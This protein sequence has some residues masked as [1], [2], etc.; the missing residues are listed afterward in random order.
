MWKYN[1]L[2]DDKCELEESLRAEMLTCEEQ[3]AYIEVLKQAMEAKVEECAGGKA[4]APSVQEAKEVKPRADESRREQAR[5]KNT[6]LDYESQIKRFQ[7]QAK[8]KEAEIG[9]TY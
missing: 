3:R 2:L 9:E 8:N 5:L 4:E 6:L 7:A 1:S